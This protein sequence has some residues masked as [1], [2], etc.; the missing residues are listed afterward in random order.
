VEQNRYTP[1]YRLLHWAIALCFILLLA[2]IFLRLTWLNKHH[3]ADIIGQFMRD[4]SP[5]LDEEAR[6][7]LAKKIRKPMW[8]W[9][10]YLG[11]AL[12]GLF[13][14]RF[15]LP[16][17]GKMRFQ[18]PLQPALTPLERFKNWTYIVFYAC[19][20]VSLLSGLG[21]KFGPKDW[22]DGLEDLHV[23]SLYYLIP[24]LVLHLGGVLHAE[25]G[26]RKGIVSRIISG[27]KN[28]G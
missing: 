8:E 23:L 1:T 18:S 4:Q 26:K 5:G 22:E 7:T 2:T 3:V 10:L 19:V 9:H 13:A 20:A 16:L 28:Q 21:M 6:I 17:V 12:S 25:F 24:Y 27:D 15:S 11:Y 14:L